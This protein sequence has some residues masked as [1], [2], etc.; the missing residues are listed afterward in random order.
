MLPPI[1]QRPRG[2]ERT[3][4]RSCVGG[5]ETVLVG[6]TGGSVRAPTLV[7]GTLGR[8]EFARSCAGIDGR[9]A[10][11]FAP[12]WHVLRFG[13]GGGGIA[14]AGTARLTCR[15]G[16]RR[17]GA[18]SSPRRARGRLRGVV[19][20]GGRGRCARVPCRRSRRSAAAPPDGSSRAP[21]PAPRRGRPRGAEGRAT[22]TWSP[23]R[24]SDR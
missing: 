12:L 18:R 14:G 20:W 9:T 22:R 21:A 19:M 16:R 15:E 17:G 6:G 4:P 24:R 7:T 1:R 5:H 10:P 2:R 11:L 8:W 13:G 3:P 23:R